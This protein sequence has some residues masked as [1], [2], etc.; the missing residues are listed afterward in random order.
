LAQKQSCPPEVLQRIFD[1]AKQAREKTNPEK[2]YALADL[3]EQTMS[4]V[5]KNPNTP[6]KL[7]EETAAGD[8]PHVRW[9]AA[10]N[11]SLPKEAKIAY[12]RKACTFPSEGERRESAK[13]VDT[14]VETLECLAADP[15]S[16]GAVVQNSNASRKALEILTKSKQDWVQKMAEEK[17]AKE[18][19]R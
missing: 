6:V 7:L 12:L 18:S 1:K 14:P 11:P 15:A 5:A 17:L 16:D 13:L 4:E 3:L 9:F 8:D 2:S 10:M 19:S